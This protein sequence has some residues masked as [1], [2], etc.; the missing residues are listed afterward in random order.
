MLF[1]EDYQEDVYEKFQ[2]KSLS[3]FTPYVIA[4]PSDGLGSDFWSSIWTSFI[5]NVPSF[6]SLGPSSSP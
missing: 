4:P 5:L 6:M 1:V 3:K 2:V